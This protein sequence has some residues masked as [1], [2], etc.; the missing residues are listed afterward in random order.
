MRK[1]TL[2]S[3][4]VF[5]A[6]LIIVLVLTWRNPVDGRQYSQGPDTRASQMLHD[7]ERNLEQRD[8]R[9]GYKFAGRVENVMDTARALLRGPQ[10]YL[11]IS[12]DGHSLSIL[13][14]GEHVTS[15]FLLTEVMN[16]IAIGDLIYNLEINGQSVKV[17]IS[18]DGSRFGGL[19]LTVS[20]IKSSHSVASR[21]VSRDCEDRLLSTNIF[22]N[23][24]EYAKACCRASCL[25]GHVQDCQLE[26]VES[27]HGYFGYVELSPNSKD[28][29][30]PGWVEGSSC[31]ANVSYT[32]GV[33]LRLPH[34]D[35]DI[36]GTG[37]EG[38]LLPVTDCAS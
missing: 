12:D 14:L 4:I 36:P 34:L 35:F 27:G 20:R 13:N 15:N 22:G 17:V 25:D 32:W 2:Y 7:M 28:T 3:L 5:F 18:A 16:T 19:F 29:P 24:A 31:H 23:R 6:L 1:K 11:I 9:V 30:K 33:R 37:G 26:A 10:Y 21:S 38:N 8:L